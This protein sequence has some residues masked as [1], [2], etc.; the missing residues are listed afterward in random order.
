MAEIEIKASQWRLV[1][2]GRVVLFTH[3]PFTG[4]LAAIVEIIDH[5]R[6]LVDG[7][8]KKENAS[9]PR[10][11]VSLNYLIITPIVIPKLPRQAGRGAVA[12]AWEKEE[13][14][15]QWDESAWA[16]RREQR[17]KRRNLSDFDRFKVLKLKKQA[18]FEVRKA[19]AKVR[20]AAK[21]S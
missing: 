4:R 14:E 3:G 1:E 13:V 18:R 11:S 9:V 5:K 6:A 19:H 2:V 17:E 10:Q 21:S 7:P 12:K 16:K 20:A 15:Q 8:S